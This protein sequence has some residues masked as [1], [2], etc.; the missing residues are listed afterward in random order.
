MSLAEKAR[1]GGRSRTTP[2]GKTEMS[3]KNI[4]NKKG[5]TP[6]AEIKTLARE[7]GGSRSGSVRTR[8][9]SSGAAES[10]TSGEASRDASPAKKGGDRGV[11]LNRDILQVGRSGSE[12]EEAPRARPSRPRTRSTLKGGEAFMSPPRPTNLPLGASGDEDVFMEA[13][14]SQSAAGSRASSERRGAGKRPRSRSRS[15]GKRKASPSPSRPPDPQVGIAEVRLSPTEEE[16]S[17][18]KRIASEAPL[19]KGEVETDSESAASEPPP[20]PSEPFPGTRKAKR[21][22][23]RPPTTG[24]YVNLAAAKEKLLQLQHEELAL[25][26]ERE[27]SEYWTDPAHTRSRGLLLGESVPTPRFH[28]R[29]RRG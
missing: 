3:A 10:A 25:T 9:S 24:E 16:E 15:L 23:G 17:P 20:R 27:L 12:D 5:E 4:K 22:R 2:R 8:G 1:P 19:K 14:D 13:L 29:A 7:V 28:E 6:P 18:A 11:S 21:D 26:A